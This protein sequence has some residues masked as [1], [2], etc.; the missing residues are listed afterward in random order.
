MNQSAQSFDPKVFH[1]IFPSRLPW[2]SLQ[3]IFRGKTGVF[4]AHDQRSGNAAELEA[5]PATILRQADGKNSLAD[6]AEGAGISLEQSG[7]DLLKNLVVMQKMGLIKTIKSTDN[8][9]AAQG[10]PIVP[11]AL[12]PIMFKLSLFNPDRVLGHFSW[13]GRAAF[14]KTAF[15]LWLAMLAFG[16]YLFWLNIVE[17]QAWVAGG[18]IANINFIY[19]ALMFPLVKVIHE[20]AH[21]LA[22]KRWGGEARDF[23]VFMLALFPIPYIDCSDSGVFARRSHRIIVA[24]AGMMVEA[25]LAFIFLLVWLLSSDPFTKE[26]AVNGLILTTVTTLIFNANPLMRFDGYYIFSEL[27]NLPNLMTRATQLFRQIIAKFTLINNSPTAPL[28]RKDYV[29]LFYGIASFFYKFYIVAIILVGV[30]ERFFVVGLLLAFWGMVEMILKPLASFTGKNFRHLREGKLRLIPLGFATLII[31]LIALVPVPYILTFPGQMNIGEENLIRAQS[32]GILTKVPSLSGQQIAHGDIVFEFKNDD[33]K[34]RIMRK[35]MEIARLTKIYNAQSISNYAQSLTTAEN[36]KMLDAQLAELEQR[37]KQQIVQADKTGTVYP[38]ND[39]L[40]GHFVS[41]GKVLGYYV[42]KDIERYATAIISH[43]DLDL[44]RSQ[45]RAFTAV[46]IDDQL[47]Q[48]PLRYISEQSLADKIAEV[49]AQQNKSNSSAEKKQLQSSF[50]VKFEFDRQF[51]PHIVSGNL[52]IRADLGNKPIA[53]QF[54][55]KLLIWLEKLLYS[56]Y[57]SESAA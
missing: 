10:R 51:A 15:T 37:H 19:M 54:Y 13:L 29:Y 44:I 35:N 12:N 14:S 8:P 30:V 34:N 50:V 40:P 1:V 20:S 21:G 38:P 48:V 22:C 11:P 31:G 28:A 27:F 39:L 43:E 41:R 2:I 25:V 23:G 55:R 24:A 32:E 3:T 17:Y 36:I 45:A 9:N 4:V 47:S 5:L 53:M 18:I 26:V 7:Q 16:L 42:T 33:L 56:R 46:Y 52:Y 49:E 57:I 6:I